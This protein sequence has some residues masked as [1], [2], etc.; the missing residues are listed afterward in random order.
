[1]PNELQRNGSQN[2]KPT[3]YADL[4]QDSIFTGL[5]TQRSP[6]RDAATPFLQRKFYGA[7][8][9]DSLIDGANVEL[10]NRLTL[11]R[12]PGH[13]VYNSSTFSSIN[14]FIGFRQYTAGSEVIKV[15]ADTATDVFNATG[16]STKTSIHT[17][18]GGAGQTHFLQ[19]GNVLFMADGTDFTQYDGTST[20][21]VGTATPLDA[22]GDA[23]LSYVGA[24]CRYWAPNMSVAA[25]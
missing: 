3:K 8:R 12:R 25:G 4:N 10:T 14:A 24:P 6:L 9:I 20:T 13:L 17:K 18:A 5:W 16:G 11:A 23:P 7:T 22:P 1:M 2:Y 21:N 19:V 15:I